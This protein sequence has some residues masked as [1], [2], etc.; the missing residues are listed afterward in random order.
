[1]STAATPPDKSV[2][3]AACYEVYSSID[4]LSFVQLSGFVSALGVLGPQLNSTLSPRTSEPQ[5]KVTY[6]EVVQAAT[7]AASTAASKQQPQQAGT[8]VAAADLLVGLGRL[9]WAPTQDQATALMSVLA[10]GDARGWQQ[11][12]QQQRL[13]PLL[14]ALCQLG[15]QPSIADLA[16]A[17][18]AVLQQ[19]LGSQQQ[20]DGEGRSG[21]GTLQQLQRD[22]A[23]AYGSFVRASYLLTQLGLVLSPQ[24]SQQLKAVVD[25]SLTLP[26]TAFGGS[27]T[28]SSSSL[29]RLDQLLADAADAL[30]ASGFSSS[31][32]SSDWLQRFAAAVEGVLPGASGSSCCRLAGG[33]A[34]LGVVLPAARG[35]LL[36]TLVKQ[37]SGWLVAG[38]GGYG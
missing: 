37:V 5:G 8:A 12:Q 7:A 1:M 32:S 18:E 6:V 23:A 31:S 24:H 15:L 11:L 26:A 28:S 34:G 20:Q 13:L 21:G 22:A 14:D 29:Y 36:P 3:G 35:S 30:V 17:A 33:L 25:R 19:S 4:R 16:S 9:G 27:S 38:S 2:L 10:A